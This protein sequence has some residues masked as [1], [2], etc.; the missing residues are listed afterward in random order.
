MKKTA[1]LAI[2]CLA[3][4]SFAG[5]AHNV[6]IPKDIKDMSLKKVTDNVYV[7]HGIHAMPDKD[8]KG[9]ISNSGI[10]VSDQ[11]VVIIDTGGSFQIGEMLL[12]KITEVTDKPVIAVFNTHLHG[13]HW[14]G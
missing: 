3:V 13:D 2:L 7:V 12:N 11:G 9:F 8:N 10:V 4:L 5:H 1:R 14:M 6:T